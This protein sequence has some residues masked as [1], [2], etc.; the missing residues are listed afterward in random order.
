MEW[1]L[2][3]ATN[4][5]DVVGVANHPQIRLLNFVGAARGGA[6]S[7]TAEHLARLTPQLFCRGRWAICTPESASFF[8]AV[9]YYFG[10]KLQQELKVPIGLISPAIGG[11]PAEAWI[12]R[13]AMAGEGELAP[14]VQGDWLKNSQLD[15]WCQR[16]AEGNL[17]R[18]RESGE[19]VPGDELG[20][21]HSFK[22]AFM[23][24]SGVS[25]LVPYAIQGV[26]WY[27]GESNAASHWRAMQHSQLFPVL[28]RDWRE[29]WGQGDFSFFYVQL[30]ALGRPHWPVFRE[31]QRRMLDKLPNVGMAVTMD[32]GHRTNVHPIDKQPVG[33]RLA[34]WALAETYGRAVTASGPLFQLMQVVDQRAILTFK[35]AG[36]VLT[37]R[38]QLAPVGFEVAG[39]EGVYFPAKAQIEGDTIIV[40]SAKVLEIANVRYGWEAFPDPPLNLINS[41][42]LPASPFTTAA[43]LLEA[44]N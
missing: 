16:R 2:K 40:S 3:N 10:R 26:I 44:R 17:L 28:V 25:P 38:D 19:H 4:G 8:S 9:G 34:R 15:A 6:G 27:Q 23:W 1:P 33:E 22:P 18:A 43:S 13:D 30:P 31:G 29:Q 39:E 20:P 42:G 35:Y 7:Y 14:L 12:R 41:E 37:T 5:H 36:Q 21:N 32:I 11:T 24:E